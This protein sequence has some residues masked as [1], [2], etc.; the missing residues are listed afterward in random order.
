M[1]PASLKK[2]QKAIIKPGIEKHLH[3]LIR[4]RGAVS[5]GRIHRLWNFAQSMMAQE[6]E[7]HADGTQRL[8]L[9]PDFSHLAGPECRVQLQSLRALASRLCASPDVQKIDPLLTEYVR[10]VFPHP[11]ALTPISEVTQSTKCW[12]VDNWRLYYS[13]RAQDYF[14]KEQWDEY[15]RSRAIDTL[16]RALEKRNRAARKLADSQRSISYPFLVHDGGRP[17]HDLLKAVNRAV[18]QWLPPDMRAD[19]CQDL[20]VGILAGDFDKDNLHLPAKEMLKRVQQMFPVKYGPLSLDAIVP[21]TEDMKLMDLIS[22]YDGV[23]P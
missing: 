2:L 19:V 18:P 15:Q 11:F 1:K 13:R 10:D 22:E 12:G 23:W 9:N 8:T 3:P 5:L 17:E 16:R 21:G 7:T 4:F 20:V 14:S 6:C